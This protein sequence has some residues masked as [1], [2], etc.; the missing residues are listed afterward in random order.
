VP[1]SGFDLI[2]ANINR[3]VLSEMMPALREKLAPGGRGIFGGLL[4]SDRTPLLKRAAACGLA[5]EEER[6][7]NEWW[8]VRMVVDEQGESE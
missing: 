2:F 5:L 3:N 6:S 7:E 8:A 4:L 1:E